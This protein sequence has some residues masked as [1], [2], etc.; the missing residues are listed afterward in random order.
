MQAVRLMV[1][2]MRRRSATT[3][4]TVEASLKVH[5]TVGV[6]SLPEVGDRHAGWYKMEGKVASC[7]TR[8][9]S[10]RSELVIRPDGFLKLTR[11][12]TISLG[13]YRRHT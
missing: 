2:R 9:A 10:S 3:G 8:A 4:L 11:S 13:H 12:S 5:D 7:S 6:L 1:E